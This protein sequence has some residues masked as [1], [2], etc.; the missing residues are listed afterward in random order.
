MKI[1]VAICTADTEYRER[2]TSYC[3]THYY[4]KF[5]WSV[6]SD[7]AWLS[8]SLEEQ[9][10]DV[11]LIGREMMEQA[12]A[13]AAATQ[14]KAVW[15]VLMED[16]EE[17]PEGFFGLQK[18]ISIDR[19]YRELLGAYAKKEN[20][21]L[22]GAAS[23]NE[24]TAVYAFVS[25]SGGAGASTLAAAAAKYYAKFGK[26][27]Y[28]NL[29]N[30]GV[31]EPAFEGEK[32]AGMDK[33]IYTL[34]SRRKALEIT[35]E[36]AV[37]RDKSGVYFFEVCENPMDMILLTGDDIRELITA[38]GLTGVYEKVIL[39]V[40]NGVGE[41]E[42][43]VMDRADRIVVVLEENEISRGKFDR[44]LKTLQT[45]ET[46]KKVDICSKMQ[47]VF[48]K[49]LKQNKLPE[50]LFRFRAAGGFPKIENGTYK[51]IVDRLSSLEMI[52]NLQ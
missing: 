29:E 50:E 42:I 48:N 30:M 17:A 27:L 38:L 33:L 16:E 10:A 13:L 46:M 1:R 35:L 44:Y 39:D 49:T 36:S 32:R 41:K 5:S 15:L 20:I 31:V 2:V 6:F 7:V 45:M 12:T 34:K 25:A 52:S 23:A 18:Y 40:G 24:K 28:L 47:L 4:D 14:G 43:A 22:P 21:R 51:G 11:V 9:P 37:S 3:R 26:T 8:S 19:L